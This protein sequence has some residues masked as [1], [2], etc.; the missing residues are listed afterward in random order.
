VRLVKAVLHVKE[1]WVSKNR[2]YLMQVYFY[3]MNLIKII[4]YFIDCACPKGYENIETEW[5]CKL[6][7]CKGTAGEVFSRIPYLDC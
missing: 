4:K 5:N 2:E 3:F 1:I 6:I 7:V